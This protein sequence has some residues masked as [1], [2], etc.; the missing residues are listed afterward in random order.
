MKQF[1]LLLSMYLYNLF[2]ITKLLTIIILRLPEIESYLEQYAIPIPAD[3]PGQLFIRRAIVN[4]LKSDNNVPTSN[5]IIHLIPFL[6]C[7][8]YHLIAMNQSSLFFGYFLI[9]YI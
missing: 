3:F 7:Y 6:V 1:N 8:M 4:V 2:I 9:N 5:N